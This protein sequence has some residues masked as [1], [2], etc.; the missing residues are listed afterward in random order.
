MLK[1]HEKTLRV[2]KLTRIDFSRG[3]WAEW[4]ANLRYRLRRLEKVEF[5]GVFR[6]IVNLQTMGMD[7]L[8]EDKDWGK[9][10]DKYGESIYAINRGEPRTIGSQLGELVLTDVSYVKRNRLRLITSM[11]KKMMRHI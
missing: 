9:F 7:V 10:D 1:R 2:L 8:M 5:R 3:V 11:I 6:E 4:F